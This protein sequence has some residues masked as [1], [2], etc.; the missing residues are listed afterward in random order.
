M[1]FAFGLAAEIERKLISDRTKSSLANI[2]AQ[3]KK[4]GRPFTAE[5]K[6]LKLSKNSRRI[7]KLLEKG[8]SKS[9]IARILGVGCGTL[10]SY[11]DRIS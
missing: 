3:D 7:K 1:A 4:L 6:K 8:M 2:K 5:S 9:E 10:R 11:L